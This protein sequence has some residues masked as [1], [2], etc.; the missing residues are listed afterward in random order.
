VSDVGR[1]AHRVTAVRT[2]FV[3]RTCRPSFFY[4]PAVSFYLSLDSVKLHYPAT[5]KKKRREYFFKKIM[6][7][8]SMRLYGTVTR[9]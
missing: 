6:F 8:S 7:E 5:N 2:T 9:F 1:V 4:T 3:V